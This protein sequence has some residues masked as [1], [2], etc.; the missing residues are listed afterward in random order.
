MRAGIGAVL[1]AK[2]EAESIGRCLE[3][4]RELDEIVVLDTGSTDG[5]PDIARKHGA[6]VF[7][8]TPRPGEEFHF[9]GARNAALARLK[10]A[11]ALSIDADEILTEGSA[12][13]IRRVAS[14]LTIITAFRL[15]YRFP[16]TEH[17]P[18]VVR[19]RV[20][21]FQAEK[22]AWRWRIHEELVALTQRPRIGDLPEAVLEHRPRALK[23]SRGDQN[24]KLLVME[25]VENPHRVL[26]WKKLAQEF[27]LREQWEDALRSLSEFKTRIPEPEPDPLEASE[28]LI[29]EGR[30][31]ARCGRLEEALSI[32]DQAAAAAPDRREPYWHGY[33]EIMRREDLGPQRIFHAKHCLEELL[34]IP[35]ERK[36]AFWLNLE[37]VWGTLPQE[38]LGNLES[39]IAQAKA[40]WESRNAGKS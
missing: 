8:E 25:T 30:C 20:R 13:A 27:A 10:S 31:H 28:T 11:W 33:V 34:K 24:V 1:I 18:A 15:S 22:Y 26:I 37:P 35:V 32:F 12:V 21:L 2:D 6:R 17:G 40:A 16:P 4:L 29:L 23:G 38:A 9:G 19:P 3:S 5:T 7:V 14:R 36:P 39:E